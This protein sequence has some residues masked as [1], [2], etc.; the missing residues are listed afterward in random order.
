MHA[1]CRNALLEKM[2]AMRGVGPA[3]GGVLGALGE[4][5]RRP[6]AQPQGSAGNRLAAIAAANREG[7]AHAPAAADRT[8]ELTIRPGME[9]MKVVSVEGFSG[10]WGASI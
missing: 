6:P 10:F 4:Q 7:C 2:V 9:A 8:L 1:R 5:R 3:G